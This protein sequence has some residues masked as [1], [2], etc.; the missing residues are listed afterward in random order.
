[1]RSTLFIS[2][3]CGLAAAAPAPAPQQIDVVGA[4]NDLVPLSVLGP[5]ATAV[6][7]AKPTYNAVAAAKSD[8]EDVPSDPITSNTSGK[9]GIQKRDA[10]STQPGG[11]GPIPGDGSV[12]AYLAGNSILAQTAQAAGTPRG[13]VKSFTNLQ[14]STQQAGYLTYKNLDGGAYNVDACAAFCD[15]VRY[16]LGFNIY[17]ER[18]PSVDPGQACPNPA[19]FTNVKCSLYGYPVAAGSATNTGQWRNQFHVVIAGSNGYS[20]MAPCPYPGALT[21]FTG[22]SDY[23]HGAINAPLDNGYDTYLGMRLFNDGPYD[24]S[25][26]A[27]VCQAT[28]AYDRATAGPD[29]KYKPCN[30]FNS[31]V[32]LKNDVPQGTYCSF[33]TRSWDS[34]YAVN[35][36]Y[37][38]GDDTYKVVGSFTYELT[39]LD[40]GQI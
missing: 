40:D 35:T 36:G 1:M 19:P 10:C 16:C 37:W 18:D 3:I 6:P 28:T 22:P 24:P 31:Y 11:N 5:D 23:L 17:Y 2:A 29:G 38:Y 25:R 34:S 9:R 8:A 39:T 27:A 26:C 14:G 32:L 33:Y 12:E 7:G 4:A 30:F 21:N 13:Y 15:S 20:K